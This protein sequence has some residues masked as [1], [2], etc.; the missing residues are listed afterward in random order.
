LLEATLA[1]LPCFPGRALF[2]VPAVTR[3]SF[4][5][6]FFGADDLLLDLLAREHP[7]THDSSREIERPPPE[8]I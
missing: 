8:K 3:K 1:T 5:E 2:L 6:L 7:V 4:D